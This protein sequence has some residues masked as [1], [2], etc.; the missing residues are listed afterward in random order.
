[1]PGYVS[2]SGR[3]SQNG[4]ALAKSQ[5]IPR[6]VTVEHGSVKRIVVNVNY[7]FIYV[8]YM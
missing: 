5:Q 8:L 1:M 2:N 6:H 3:A 7:C 4:L